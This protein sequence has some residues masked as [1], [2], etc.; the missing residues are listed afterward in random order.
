MTV[1]SELILPFSCS[2]P[3]NRC[4]QNSVSTHYYVRHTHL[5]K[6]MWIM[7]C[8]R[9]FFFLII[10]KMIASYPASKVIWRTSSNLPLSISNFSMILHVNH[11]S[12]QEKWESLCFCSQFSSI[13]HFCRS[14]LCSP[15]LLLHTHNLSTSPRSIRPHSINSPILLS[16]LRL[17]DHS[18]L[19][20]VQNLFHHHHWT[21]FLLPQHPLTFLPL[22]TRN[23]HIHLLLNFQSHHLLTKT[24]L[25]ILPSSNFPTSILTPLQPPPHPNPEMEHKHKHHHAQKHSERN[26]DIRVY[27]S[28]FCTVKVGFRGVEISVQ[29]VFDSVPEM[30]EVR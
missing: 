3:S 24:S 8:L 16:L 19:L 23:T 9:M 11:K 26:P 12:L 7:E 13:L 1:G 10:T 4:F 14:L 28:L 21:I 18:F 17:K 5:P 2:S 22:L 20:L 27:A 29:S 6:R 15:S 30:V 25:H